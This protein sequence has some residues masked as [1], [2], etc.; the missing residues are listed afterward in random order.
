MKKMV[1][2]IRVKGECLPLPKG[3]SG[4]AP[5]RSIQEA[6]LFNIHISDP[7]ELTD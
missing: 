7:E 5:H 1:W 2:E 6:A 4:G 3:L